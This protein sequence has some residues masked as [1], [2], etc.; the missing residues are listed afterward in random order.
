[1]AG[2]SVQTVRVDEVEARLV[3]EAEGEVKLAQ[4]LSASWPSLCFSWVVDDDVETIDTH[5]ARL[6]HF[7]HLG[8]PPCLC[9]RHWN[10]RD[11]EVLALVG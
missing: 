4:H 5:F 10:E 7:F 3:V 1:M 11:Q 6:E 9:H 8:L 2:L